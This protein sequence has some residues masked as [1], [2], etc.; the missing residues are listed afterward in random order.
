MKILRTTHR[1]EQKR[2]REQK[3]EKK[4]EREKGTTV[5]EA[6]LNRMCTFTHQKYKKLQNSVL[7]LGQIATRFTGRRGRAS[8]HVNSIGM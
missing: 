8:P 7:V 6:V 1:T 3:K 4:K 2:R 5:T